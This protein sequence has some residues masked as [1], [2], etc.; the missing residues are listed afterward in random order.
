[1][2]FY[3]EVLGSVGDMLIGCQVVC[4]HVVFEHGGLDRCVLKWGVSDRPDHFLDE[5]LQWQ[6]GLECSASSVGCDK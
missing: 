1:M 2:P 5:P 6:V 3:K 4:S